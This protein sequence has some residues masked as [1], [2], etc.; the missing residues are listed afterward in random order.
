MK[1][2]NGSF[3]KICCWSHIK[4]DRYKRPFDQC[5][6][7]KGVPNVVLPKD[8]KKFKFTSFHA[9]DKAP[10]VCYFDTESVLF[11]NTDV[12]NSTYRHDIASYKYLKVDKDGSIVAHKLETGGGNFWRRMI[13]RISANFQKIRC[14]MK[15]KLETWTSFNT[16]RQ[17]K[18]W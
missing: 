10:F 17:G 8:R 7:F 18:F 1:L 14:D 15:K 3:C 6:S 16:E 5:D 2:V 4:T 9:R 11:P 13:D 12:K